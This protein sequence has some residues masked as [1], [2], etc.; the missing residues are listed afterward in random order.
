MTPEATTLP[1]HPT[2][3]P[4]YGQ[5]EEKRKFLQRIFDDTAADYDRM[6]YLASFGTGP[7]YRGQALQRAGLAAG[8]KVLD[9][10]VG[11]GLVAREEIKLVGDPKLVTGLDPSMGMMQLAVQQLGIRAILGVGESLP[12]SSDQFDF[13][14]MGY[15]L[16]HLADL[17]VT[18]KEFHRVLK[19]G[20]RVLILEISR[21]ANV[22]HRTLLRT[23]MKG[24]MP[25]ISRMIGRRADTQK[26]WAYYWETIE[27]CVPADQV[28]E[29][30]TAAGFTDVKRYCEW[31]MFSEFTATKA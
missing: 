9:V 10:A 19:P 1:P 12:I 7:W 25:L 24:I 27:Q 28:L 29:A 18:F 13:L 5:A 30:L 16:R 3:S 23:Y 8:M 11:T 22:V 14:S 20:G 6:D 4:Y 21:P 15:A 31:G 26:L 2:L 17:R